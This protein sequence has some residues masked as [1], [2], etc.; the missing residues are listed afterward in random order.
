MGDLPFRLV[1][2][3]VGLAAHVLVA[4]PVLLV[5]WV[6]RLRIRS[7]LKIF[8]TIAA[9]PPT[10]LFLFWLLY[11]LHLTAEALVLPI[12]W[13]VFGLLVWGAVR[14]L[15]RYPPRGDDG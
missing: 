11:A 13:I 7:V 6:W 14:L 8:V 9:V 4:F 15:S 5:W 12:V 1:I 3:L 10:L 2:L